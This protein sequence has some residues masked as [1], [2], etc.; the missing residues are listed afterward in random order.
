MPSPSPMR[1]PET[2]CSASWF[3]WLGAGLT[4]EE[5]LS[6]FIRDNELAWLRGTVL[7]EFGEPSGFLA[8]KRHQ[9]LTAPLVMPATICRL[10]KMYMTSGGIVISRMSMNSRFHWLQDLALE[11]VERELDRGV[12]RRRAGSTAGSVKSLNTATA[13]TT[14]TVTITG[15]SS[16]S[17]TWKNSRRGPA[18][19]MHRRLVELPRDGRDER[20]EQQDAERQPERRPR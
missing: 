2:P 17:T 13:C 5:T 10:K 3:E 12:R 6:I 14:M 8:R 20:A 1:N 4:Q 11:V 18:P 16:G 7:A 9:P 15:R 19:S